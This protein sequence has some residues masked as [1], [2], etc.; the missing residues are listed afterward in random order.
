[1][2]QEPRLTSRTGLNPPGFS[3]LVDQDKMIAAVFLPAIF[4]GLSTDPLLFALTDFAK[5]IRA[6]SVLDERLTGGFGTVLAER[7]VVLGGAA[8][9]ATAFNPHLPVVLLDQLRGLGQ[10]LLRVRTEVGFVIVK[11]NVFDGLLEELFFR[12]TGRLHRRW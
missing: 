9:V 4:I 11:I 3:W 8:L 7:E 12:E 5:R 10:R 1:V 2:L 6:N